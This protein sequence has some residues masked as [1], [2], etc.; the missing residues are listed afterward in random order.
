MHPVSL[1]VPMGG[2]SPLMT[3]STAAPSRYF[4]GR[5]K[6]LTFPIVFRCSKYDGKL[7][8]VEWV[9]VLF[10]PETLITPG[11]TGDR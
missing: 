11:I 2:V 9:R 1:Y 5:Q 10:G 8:V 4:Q 3:G 7:G 6:E